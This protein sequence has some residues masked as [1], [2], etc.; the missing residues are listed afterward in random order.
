MNIKYVYFTIQGALDRST[1]LKGWTGLI[2]AGFIQ[3]SLTQR[4]VPAYEQP[5]GVLHV[6]WL[7]HTIWIVFFIVLAI[8]RMHDYNRPTY[9]AF[10]LSVPGID[11][12]LILEMILRKGKKRLNYLPE[13]Q[14][15][16]YR[17][18]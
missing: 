17:K 2:L 16:D 1:F 5:L 9:T 3:I 13:N 12:F 4:L 8:K 15:Q 14:K 18:L 10:L 11:V 6:N 7:F